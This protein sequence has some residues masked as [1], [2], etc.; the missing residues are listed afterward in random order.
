[1]GGSADPA[2]RHTG[3]LVVTCPDR[4]GIVAAVSAFLFARAANITHADQHSSDPTGG[5][6]FL[7]VVL[8]LMAWTP[9]SGSCAMRSVPRW[10]SRSGW[11]SP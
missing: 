8:H 6:F 5:R 4:P 10:P 7:R 3:R 9:A 1:V 11:R 2:R